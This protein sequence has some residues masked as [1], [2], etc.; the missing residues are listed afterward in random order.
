MCVVIS[1]F[2]LKHFVW[3]NFWFEHGL[4]LWYFKLL[5]LYPKQSK[6]N[7]ITR[8]SNKKI[9]EYGSKRMDTAHPRR[10]Y[11]VGNFER[12][13]REAWRFNLQARCYESACHRIYHSRH[14]ALGLE[15][16]VAGSHNSYLNPVTTRRPV[17]ESFILISNRS[18]FMH[19]KK[20]KESVG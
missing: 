2:F 7:K 5:A 8:V 16:L 9:L 4:I 11:R 10:F 12:D 15:H 13:R 20:Q 18:F 14:F 17:R 3:G 19:R 6:N 1:I